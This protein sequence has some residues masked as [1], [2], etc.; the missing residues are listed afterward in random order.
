M[1][2]FRLAHFSDV[3]LGPLPD[4]SYREL[5]SKRI[6]GYINW[7]RNR[8]GSF[9][10]RVIESI[11]DDIAIQEPDH[12]ALTGDLVNLAL[13]AEIELARQWLTALPFEDHEVTVVPGNHDTY[14]T[15]ALAKACRAWRPFMLGDGAAEGGRVTFPFLRRRGPVALIGVSSARAMLP[16]VAAGIFESRQ[17]KRVAELLD[18]A[19]REGLYRVV[20]IHH[21]PVRGATGNHKR[22]YGIARFQRMIARHGAELVLHGHTH[23]ATTH[24][25]DGPAGPRTVPVIGVPAGGQAHGEA[26]TPAQ[27]NLFE[28]DGDAGGWRTRLVRRGVV[29][30]D[31]AIEDYG[32]EILW[33]PGT[34]PE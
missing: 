19:G 20:L 32:E 2:M 27:Y 26:K 11:V 6:T 16:F 29:G 3:H 25:I 10:T 5:A 1:I 23:L 14:V 24:W 9:Q 18:E 12:V 30:S 7:R 28:I 17:A 33:G 31:A 15:G 21:P 34:A 13:D 22:L 4:V 8:R